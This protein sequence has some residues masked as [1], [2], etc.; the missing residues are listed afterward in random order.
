MLENSNYKLFPQGFHVH[1]NR[2]DFDFRDDDPEFWLRAER[3]LCDHYTRLIQ[4]ILVERA[5]NA[6][7][8]IAGFAPIPMLVKLGALVG[9]KTRA[10]VLDL[11]SDG[12][13]WDTRDAC[14]EPMFTY[15]VP[16]ALPR[17]I[18]IVVSISGR[19]VHPTALPLV[20]FQAVAPDRGI[21]RKE[22]HLQAFRSSF[23]AFLQRVTSAGARIVHLH[24]ATP[25]AASVEI[26][27]MMLPKTFEEIHVWEWQAPN[28]KPALRVK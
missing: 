28:W 18:S 1:I 8:T 13:L 11:P 4:P 23:N 27:R 17:E 7:L 12:W 5:S 26:G 2:S 6:H 24:P 9:D 19:A 3:A 22:A 16:S 10:N 20:E 21:I 15:D 25:L 14:P